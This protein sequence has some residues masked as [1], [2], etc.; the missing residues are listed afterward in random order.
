MF[1]EAGAN[2]D[3]IEMIFGKDVRVNRNVSCK[4]HFYQCANQQAGVD[5]SDKAKHVFKTLV[6]NVFQA[7][8]PHLYN[9]ARKKLFAFAEEKKSKRSHVLT[10]FKWW[11]KRTHIL[12]AFKSSALSYSKRQFSRGWSLAVG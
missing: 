6:R 4:F 9:Q 5:W 1:D 8:M 12:Y 7:P 3:A 10:W 11:H 2:W